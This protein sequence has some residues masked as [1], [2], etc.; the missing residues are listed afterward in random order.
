MNLA[1]VHACAS[2]PYWGAAFSAWRRIS[3]AN[4]K[5]P[6]YISTPYSAP[7]TAIWSCFRTV[8]AITMAKVAFWTDVSMP[9]VTDC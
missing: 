9:S 7:G 6:A 4:S 5:P 3:Q 2:T 1:W 8:L